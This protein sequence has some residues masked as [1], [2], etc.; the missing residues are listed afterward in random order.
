MSRP[1]RNDGKDDVDLPDDII[2]IL[3]FTVAE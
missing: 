2:N 3:S 1:I